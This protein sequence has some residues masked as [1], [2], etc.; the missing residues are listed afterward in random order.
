MNYPALP[1]K[2]QRTNKQHKDAT[3][4]A[5]LLS[6]RL[7]K[8]A[9]LH[10]LFMTTPRLIRSRCDLSICGMPFQLNTSHL[11][12]TERRK[13]F[14]NDSHSFILNHHSIKAVHYNRHDC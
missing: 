10:C 5:L 11:V 9:P 4:P 6:F 7:S 14:R 2:D 8:I 3:Q 12:E 13:V 1:I